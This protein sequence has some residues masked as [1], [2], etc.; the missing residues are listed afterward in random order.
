[1]TPPLPHPAQ[2]PDSAPVQ[3]GDRGDRILVRDLRVW[4]HVGVLEEERRLGQWFAI[5]FAIAADLSA[6]ARSDDLEGGYDYGLAITALQRL[7]RGLRCRTLEHT[8]D[9]L[10]DAL[11]GLHGPV[12]LAL[13][14]RKC[15]VPVAGFSGSVAVRRQ[16]RWPAGDDPLGGF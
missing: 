8:A 15:Q 13:E 6:T 5:S 3:A 4:A 9:R 16:R 10:L 1:V 7:A 12:G 2:S 14:I 11:E